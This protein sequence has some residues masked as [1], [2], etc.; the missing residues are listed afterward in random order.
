MPL[1]DRFI[2]TGSVGAPAAA[3]WSLVISVMLSSATPR[4]RVNQ[5]SGNRAVIVQ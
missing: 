3:E 5:G 4:L 2:R 1:S